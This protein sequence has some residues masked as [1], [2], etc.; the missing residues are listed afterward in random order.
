MGNSAVRPIR[1]VAWSVLVVA[2]ASGLGL[3]AGRVALVGNV[4]AQAWLPLLAAVIAVVGIGFAVG[5][6]FPWPTRGAREPT[7]PEPLL[8]EPSVPAIA[9]LP[10]VISLRALEPLAGSTTLAFNLGVRAAASGAVH[11]RRPR[12]ICLLQAGDLTTALGLTPEPLAS[13]VAGRPVSVEDDIVDVVVRH[14]SGC[15]LLCIGRDTLDGHWLRMLVPRLRKFYDLIVIDCP[16]DD[17]WLR[18]VAVDVSD[19]VLLVGLP[20]LASAKAAADEADAAWELRSSHRF[21]EVT[22]REKAGPGARDGLWSGLSQRAAI[23]NDPLVAESDRQGLP[24]SLTFESH[25]ARAAAEL[26]ERLLPSLIGR[27]VTSAA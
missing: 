5:A 8:P 24:W 17:R 7:D 27:E 13:Y 19:V 11:G 23:P 25:A 18:H 22:N 9:K 12:P 1:L 15:E 26:L 16:T 21:V 4:L 14:P 20:T 6:A 2:A 10:A 3:I